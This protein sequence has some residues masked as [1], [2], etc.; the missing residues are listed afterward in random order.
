MNQIPQ[1]API[2]LPKSLT[3]DRSHWNCNDLAGPRSGWTM[4]IS[5]FE[6]VI[7]GLTVWVV[8]KSVPSICSA[9]KSHSVNGNQAN[10]QPIFR[11]CP[12]IKGGPLYIQRGFGEIV[13]VNPST[14]DA[15]LLH[16]EEKRPITSLHVS[17]DG[18]TY[19]M[20][21]EDQLTIVKRGD[22]LLVCESLNT[23]LETTCTITLSANGKTALRI[24]D[25]T[26]VRRWNLLADDLEG[27]DY[28][29]SEP[30]DRAEL[31]PTGSKL[32]TSMFDGTISIID[33]RTG[34]HLQRLAQ[35]MPIIGDPV[36]SNDGRW[37]V[38]C[39]IHAVVLFDSQVGE[40][41][42]KS[43][44]ELA[45]FA[46]IAISSD[47]RWVAA[48]CVSGGIRLFDGRSGCRQHEIDISLMTFG[49]AFA[50]DTNE[51]YVGLADGSIQVWKLSDHS[52][53][54]CSS[55]LR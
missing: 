34:N 16:R 24:L 25:G 19:V 13:A 49:I 40:I 6:L 9:L 41:V 35:Q 44:D 28:T 32:C 12:A 43:S 4:M 39:T 5:L 10:A 29:L 36:W 8:M 22:E 1:W 7:I 51:L 50:K 2:N 15:V 46:R 3:I 33:A 37:L 20:S 31:D 54:Q 52:P 27:C 11:I 53:P 42:W 47:G 18:G 45:G 17:D 48:Q 38:V 14:H 26:R 23:D 30:V 21:I 55:I